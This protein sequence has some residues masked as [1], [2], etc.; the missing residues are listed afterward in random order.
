MRPVLTA[1]VLLAAWAGAAP[2]QAQNRFWLVN[3]SG[4]TIERAYVS[5]SR[6]SDWGHDILEG[7][8]LTPG[9]QV[10]VSPSADDCELDVKVEYES[11]QEEEKMEVN[12]CRTN[13]IVF[14]NPAGRAALPSPALV[15]YIPPI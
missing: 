5:P 11:G 14:T 10:R 2:A 6:L 13:R 4:L 15:G 12:A 9:Q 3:E 7:T 1:L 8:R